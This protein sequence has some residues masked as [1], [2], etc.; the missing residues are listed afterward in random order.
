MSAAED[1]TSSYRLI[2]L[3]SRRLD[4][5]SFGWWISISATTWWW[6]SQNLFWTTRNYGSILLC[7]SSYDCWWFHGVVDVFFVH[8]GPLGT[9]W[10]LFSSIQATVWCYH[11]KNLWG[12][13]WAH[14]WLCFTKKRKFPSYFSSEVYIIPE[15]QTVTQVREQFWKLHSQC[16]GP[17]WHWD[18]LKHVVANKHRAFIISAACCIL[19]CEEG[20]PVVENVDSPSAQEEKL[21]SLTL[22]ASGTKSSYNEDLWETKCPVA[23]L[24]TNFSQL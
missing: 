9:N 1:H 5:R 11:V 4:K 16:S 15:K 2:K 3:D 23:G 14:Y 19:D 12:T 18:C 7:I 6:W 22:E 17:W 21:D 10:A 13:F 8:F 20:V 24:S